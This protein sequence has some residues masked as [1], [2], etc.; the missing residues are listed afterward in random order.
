L[1]TPGDETTIT[2]VLALKRAAPN[3]AY[4][5]VVVATPSCN[6]ALAGEVTTNK[7]GNGTLEFTVPRPSGAKF[8][9]LAKT[10]VEP[11]FELYASPLV[12][13]D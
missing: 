12:E 2:G 5:V 9:V 6:L 3:T 7:E 13:L 8:F 10:V 1:N 11:P 4:G